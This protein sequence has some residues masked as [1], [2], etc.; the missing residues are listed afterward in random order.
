MIDVREA[1]LNQAYI[2]ALQEGTPTEELEKEMKDWYGPYQ[3]PA[4]KEALENEASFGNIK[5]Q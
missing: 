3:W 4:K 5:A 2:K 1:N